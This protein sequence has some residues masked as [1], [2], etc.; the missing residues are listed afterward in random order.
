MKTKT[1]HKPPKPVRMMPPATGWEVIG[2]VDL[3]RDDA[4]GLHRVHCEGCGHWL[5]YV[6]L[7]EHPEW[8]ERLVVG[9]ACAKRMTR[10]PHP[11]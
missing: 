6:H 10:R 11:P 3:E 8:H 7:I 9:A 2:V 4:L 1:K 5:R